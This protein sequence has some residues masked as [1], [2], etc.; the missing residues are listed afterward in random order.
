LADVSRDALVA[1]QRFNSEI[2]RQQPV[3]ERGSTAANP[4]GPYAGEDKA[5]AR[6]P[7]ECLFSV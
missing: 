6:L 2:R 3:T 4:S 7:P 5:V 1:Q